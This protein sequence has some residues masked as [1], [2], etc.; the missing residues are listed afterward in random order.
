[1]LLNT[2]PSFFSLVQRSSPHLQNE[3][4]WEIRKE[5]FSKLQA[6]RRNLILPEE[7]QVPDAILEDKDYLT[8]LRDIVNIGSTVE[9]HRMRTSTRLEKCVK[10]FQT[11]GYPPTGSESPQT[12]LK[13]YPSQHVRDL[14]TSLFKYLQMHWR[15]LCSKYEPHRVRKTQLSS[16]SHRR[17]EV[18]SPYSDI[19]VDAEKAEAMFQILLSTPSGSPE[20]Q[21]TEVHVKGP[22]YKFSSYSLKF[23]AANYSFSLSG[24]HC[25][26]LMKIG[27]KL[28]AISDK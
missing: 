26:P 9:R 25:L 11:L 13:K 5:R 2:T 18:E 10:H 12:S 27:K 22:K 3:R 24:A 19:R 1:M 17:F 8:I 15:C 16:T 20:W 28:M 7:D 6:L 23:K 21:D 4:R 14:A